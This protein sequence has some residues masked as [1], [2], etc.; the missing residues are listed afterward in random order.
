[1][2]HNSANSYQMNTKPSASFTMKAKIHAL[3]H[4]SHSIACVKRISSIHQ[5]NNVYIQIFPYMYIHTFISNDSVASKSEAIAQIRSGDYWN[6]V[7]K[8]IWGLPP[9]HYSSSSI[10]TIHMSD[11]KPQSRPLSSMLYSKPYTQISTIFFS[12]IHVYSSKCTIF[13]VSGILILF[14][15][16]HSHRESRVGLA[17]KPQVQNVA[18][19]RL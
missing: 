8:L 11:K 5:W 9:L 1:M 15:F 19:Q 6:L 14:I 16:L 2:N 3:L 18:Q 12:N 13:N 10:V 4:V 7:C 17:V